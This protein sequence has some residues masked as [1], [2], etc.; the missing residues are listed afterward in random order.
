MRRTSP[1]PAGRRSFVHAMK[2]PTPGTS[3]SKGNHDADRPSTSKMFDAPDL[4]LDGFSSKKPANLELPV[5]EGAVR[6]YSLQHG[7]GFL[8]IDGF[9][10]NVFVH[11]SQI[12]MPGLRCLHEG[13]RC[14]FSVY[15]TPKGLR[16]VA[17]KAIDPNGFR[18]GPPSSQRPVKCFNCGRKGHLAKDCEGAKDACHYC[19]QPGHIGANCPKKREKKERRE[20]AQMPK[21]VEP[22]DPRKKA[23]AR[24]PKA[25]IPSLRELFQQMQ[26][27]QKATLEER[28]RLERSRS[29]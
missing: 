4:P 3:T 23:N 7:S 29:C 14:R 10:E 17:V 12:E 11:Q 16:A 20:A 13:E 25:A 9:E 19:R 5:V 18:G 22:P 27:T 8:M 6:S 1:N 26:K 21:L 28:R 24:R 2:K 15:R